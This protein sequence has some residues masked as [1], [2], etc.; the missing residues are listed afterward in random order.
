[1]LEE[2]ITRYYLSRNFNLHSSLR[3]FAQRFNYKCH[4]RIF[5]DGKQ[6][7]DYIL[8]RTS[9]FRPVIMEFNIGPDMVTTPHALIEFDTGAEKDDRLWIPRRIGERNVGGHAIVAAASFSINQKIKF[10][11]LDSNWNEPRV[12][13]AES[14]LQGKTAITEMIFHSCDPI[15]L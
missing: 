2:S 5:K 13:D 11:V 14:Y 12:W 4:E 1:M 6:A 9:Q 15:D 8:A 10:L 7:S 3:Y